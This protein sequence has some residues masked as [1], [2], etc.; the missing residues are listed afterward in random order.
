[1]AEFDLNKATTT[2]FTNTVP[3]FIVESMALDIAN[4]DGSETFVY[5]DRATENYGYYFNHP[6]VA[7]P[8]NSLA[9][10]GF[11]KGWTTED[12]EMEIML[13]GITGDGKDTF[14]EI[15]WNQEV[16]KLI[17]GDSFAVIVRGDDQ[18]LVNLVPV[19]V[20]RVKTVYLGA[21]I[22]RYEI[23]NGKKWVKKR[24]QEIFHLRNKRIADQTK[25]TSLIQSNKNVYDAGIEAFEDERVIKH[26][27]KALGVVYYKTNNEGKIT[28]ANKQIENA[29]K[30]G[31][32]VG[33]PEDTAKIEPYPSK[34]SEDRQNW[35]QYVEN[36]GYQTGGV[37]RSIATSDGTSEVG[38][39]MGHVIFEPI[40]GKEQMDME[41]QL[42]N[43]ISI[44]IKFNRPPSLGGMEPE[45]DEAKNTGQ[46]GIQ[47]NDVE[48]SLTRE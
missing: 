47:P 34:S 31:E 43:Q 48:A 12:R 5:Y 37:P 36:L 45:L 28:F 41:N 39:K 7:S 46:I 25:G 19:S 17:Q 1:M 35:L 2:D 6:Q 4:A 23:W 27:D 22:K 13:K 9:T 21:V 3:N 11:G 8:I 44:K 10:W 15:I 16:N 29:V 18:N 30:K 32:M 14:D 26:R 40:Y 24:T 38:G 33:L 20:E 42:W